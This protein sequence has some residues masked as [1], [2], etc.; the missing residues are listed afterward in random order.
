MPPAATNAIE[1]RRLEKRYGERTALAGID[2]D[3][4]RGI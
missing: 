3:V 2:L 4:S 1:V